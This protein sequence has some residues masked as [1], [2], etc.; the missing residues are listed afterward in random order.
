MRRPSSL[1]GCGPWWPWTWTR[2]APWTTWPPQL[3][4]R[5]TGLGSSGSGSFAVVPGSG[6]VGTDRARVAVDVVADLGVTLVLTVFQA[7]LAALRPLLEDRPSLRVAFDHCAFPD[8]ADGVIVGGQP[9]L[10][11]ADLPQVSLKV[12]S[13]LFGS[14]GG[15]GDPAPLLDQLVQHFGA[16]RLVWGSDY[17]QTAHGTYRELVDLGRRAVRHLDP[18]GRSAVLSDNAATLFD[19]HPPD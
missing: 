7:Q 1:T 6:W 13:H 2:R 9:V 18:A 15:D 11:L 8:I 10:G 16:D 17:P 12:S 4:G 19:L 3:P 14:L 5:P